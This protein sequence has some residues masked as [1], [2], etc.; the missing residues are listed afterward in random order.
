MSSWFH[1]CA[2]VSLAA[3]GAASLVLARPGPAQRTPSSEPTPAMTVELVVVPARG[4]PSRAAVAAVR[5]ADRPTRPKVRATRRVGRSARVQRPGFDAGASVPSHDDTGPAVTRPPPLTGALLEELVAPGPRQATER[6]AL[7]SGPSPRI[8]G[9]RGQPGQTRDARIQWRRPR[10]RAAV[11]DGLITARIATDGSIE[12]FD[13]PPAA[14][15]DSP[16]SGSFDV[17]DMVMRAVGMDPYQARKL[18]L[19]DATRD[20]RAAMA[21]AEERQRLTLAV[22]DMPARLLA[23]WND[24]SLGIER[25]RELIF[26]MWDECAESGSSARMQASRAVRATIEAFVRQHAPSGSRSA[27][28]LSE[29]DRLNRRRRAQTP[30]A[31]YAPRDG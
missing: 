9:R 17:G 19:M 23:I 20:A 21:I 8:P 16:L 15:L 6:S 27:Y 26:L 1:R 2:L 14:R 22:G 10:N 5:H 24:P 3:H 25:R 13:D 30:F 12:A 11:S 18:A 7:E 4:L 28:S 29:L 31:P